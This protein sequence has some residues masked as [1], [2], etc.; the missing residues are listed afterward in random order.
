MNNDNTKGCLAFIIILIL[1]FIILS[2][3][4]GITDFI[5]S[6]LEYPVVYYGIPVLILIILYFSNKKNDD[7]S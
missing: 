3:F 4:M 1:I 7:K 6:I 5:G 2:V